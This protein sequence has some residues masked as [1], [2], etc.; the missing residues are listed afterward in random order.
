MKFT[1]AE[2][3]WKEHGDLDVPNK[4]VTLQGITL[5]VWIENQRSIAL[6][7][8]SGA[9]PLTEKQKKRLTQIGMIWREE[10]NQSSKR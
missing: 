1:E 4:Y 5:G 7:K 6:G 2:K 10:V 8:K 3:Y 9:A